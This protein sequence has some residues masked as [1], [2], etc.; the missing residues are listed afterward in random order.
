[1]GELV[2]DEVGD[3]ELVTLLEGVLDGE[4][5]G[6]PVCEGVRPPEMDAV[7][8]GVAVCEL[9]GE[10]VEVPLDEGVSDDEG[11]PVGDGVAVGVPVGGKRTAE[12]LV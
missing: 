10:P 6:E 11:V 7:G 9:E 1:M 8:V 3:G 4:P 5:V 2:T 12:R